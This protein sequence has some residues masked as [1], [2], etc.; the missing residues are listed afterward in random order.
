MPTPAPL[1]A[2]LVGLA[3]TP[4]V[5]KATPAVSIVPQE[6]MPVIRVLLPVL[7]VAKVPTS[8]QRDRAPV[9]SAPLVP[10]KTSKVRL[11]ATSAHRGHIPMRSLCP[12]VFFA[13]QVSMLL[14][15][16]TLDVSVVR[17]VV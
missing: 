14:E 6:P 12:L 10:T 15:V 4:T 11:H 16:A 13:N 1:A 2:W 8:L 3:N 17:Q 5:P 9:S 7:S